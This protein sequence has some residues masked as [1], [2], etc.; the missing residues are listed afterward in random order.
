[1]ICGDD[2]DILR[3]LEESL[4]VAD[5]RFDSEYMDKILSPTFSSLAA[6]VEYIQERKYLPLFLKKLTL[7]C[8]SL[9]SLFIISIKT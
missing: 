1:M 5:T 9:T 8:L 2:Y 6:R 3:R 7:L 4:W